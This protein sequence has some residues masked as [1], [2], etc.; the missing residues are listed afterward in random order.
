MVLIAMNLSS[1]VRNKMIYNDEGEKGYSKHVVRTILE[2]CKSNNTQ[3]LV[4]LNAGCGSNWLKKYFPKTCKVVGLDINNPSADIS[5]DLEKK[6]PI[7]DNTYD[8]IVLLH[9]VEHV[10]NPLAMFEEFERILK[11]GGV[12]Y[13]STPSPWSDNAWEDPYHTRPF[14]VGAIRSL[15]QDAQLQMIDGFYSNTAYGFGILGLRRFSGFY[16][17]FTLKLRFLNHLN[18]FKGNTEALLRKPVRK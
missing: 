4:V 12:L 14:T 3:N 11:P 17:W 16:N 5:A 1:N 7:K 2:N 8:A 13:L 10:R 15:A 6:L 18:M 9:V